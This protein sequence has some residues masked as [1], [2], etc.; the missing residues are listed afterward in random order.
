MFAGFVVVFGLVMAAEYVAF[1]HGLLALAELQTAGAALTLYL[2]E[3]FMVL[4]LFI[5]LVSFVASGLWI[6]YRASDTR[7]L[8]TAPLP[9]GGLYV[10]RSVETFAL[11]SWAM[12]VLGLP[13][14]LALGTAFG[15]PLDFYLAALGLGALFA[16]LAGGAGALLTTVA[17]AVFR[18]APT[19]LAIGAVVAALALGFTLLVGKNVV[20][21]TDDF[22]A[23][24]E[25]GIPNGKP[26]SIKFIEGKFRL[27]PTHPFATTLYSLATGD[28][29]GSTA[30]RAALWLAPLAALL[31]AGTLG[32]S[33]YRGTLPA[34]AE[35]FVLAAGAG[36][37]AREHGRGFPRRLSGPIGALVERELLAILRSP[38]ELGRAG[39]LGLLLLL[40]TSF[41]FLAPL[42]EVGTRPEAVARLLLFNVL[43]CGYFVTAFGLR[44]AFPSMSLEGRGAWVL[45][46]SPVRVFRLVLAKAFLY[47]ALLLVAVV[48]IA[49]AGILRLVDDPIV[50]AASLSLLLMLVVTT[51]TLLLSFGAAWP[52]FREGNP[53]ALS[54][55]GSGLAGTVV[56]LVYVALIGWTARNLVLAASAGSVVGWT[57]AAA[58]VSAALV[59]AALTLVSR[60]LG[61]LEAP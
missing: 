26:G 59:V 38:H 56:C 30:T 43:A 11:T 42:G 24:F 9:L 58:V 28:V 51:A 8:L 10:L 34:I 21:S 54:T 57:A 27:W 46:S 19:R 61:T 25:P 33:L 13:A 22:L 15:R 31:A 41:I 3:S 6:F 36:T 47:G 39:F 5:S 50:V 37:R 52:D 49:M 17:G 29:A 35:G 12:A 45:F 16:G 48:P 44:F 14:L 4:V 40:Y 53:E 60:R 20:P 32:R 18:R 2:L 23:I 1:R 7:L 55:S